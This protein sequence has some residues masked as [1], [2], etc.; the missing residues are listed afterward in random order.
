MSV[1]LFLDEEN[2]FM[3]DINIGETGLEQD[4]GLETAVL[5]SLFSDAR[6]TDEQLPPDFTF[7]RG[8]WADMFA[9]KNGDKHGSLL[10]LLEREKQTVEILSKIEEYCR[11]S[12]QWMID[13][14]IA[15]DV[16]VQASHPRPEFT[17]FAV[18]ITKPDGKIHAFKTLWDGQKL[19]RA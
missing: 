12:L 14:G 19:K 6:C 8:Y 18:S 16:S 15:K 11:Q 4:D 9:E 13:D 1:G 5:I 3:A 17:L 7:K 10:W 2:G